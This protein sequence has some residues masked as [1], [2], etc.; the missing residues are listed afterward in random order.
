MKKHNTGKL[1]LLLYLLTGSLY[2]AAQ[3]NEQAPL[4]AGLPAS[5]F[6]LQSDTARMRF[7]SKAIDDSLDASQLDHVMQWARTGLIIAEK[8][9]VDTMKGIFLFDIGKAFTFRYNQYDSA[10]VY[11]KKVLPYFPDRLSR[12]NFWTTREIMERYSDLGNKDSSFTYLNMLTAVV[13]TMPDSSPRKS[14]I[15]QNIAGVYQGFGM[16]RTAMRYYQVA[17]TGTRLNKN[18]GGLG[19][20]L[21]NLAELYNQ[22]GNT[23]KAIQYS[24]EALI[25]LANFNMPYMQTAGNIAEYYT[26]QLNYDSALFYLN[27]SIAIAKKTNDF[28]TGIINQN[29][30]ALIYIAQKKFG[31]AKQLLDKSLR[32]LSGTENDW[33]RCKT[34]LDHATLDT[35]IADWAGAK[36]HLQEAISVALK[37]NFTSFTVP[38]FE[39]L[40]TVCTKTGDLRSA[41]DYHVKYVNM[42]DSL[43]DEKTKADLADLEVSY[44]TQ[45][46]EN[47][48]ELLKKDNDIKKLELSN[49]K[50]SMILY[51]SLLVFVILL[52]SILYY[53]RTQRNKIE[54][55]KLKAELETQVLRLQMNPH[56]IFNSLN[57]IEN[58]IM[59]NE[60]RL[61]SDY[62]NKFARL[63]RMILDSSRNELVP[64]AKDMEALQ[65]YVDL[66][67]LRFNNKFSYH[68]IV[69]PALLNGDYRVPSLLVQPY[70]ENA[71]VHGL[72]HSEKDNLT[73]TVS[74]TMENN[75]IKYSIT[76]N[77][78]GRKQA[79]EY[80]SQNKPYHKSVGLSITENRIINFNNGA[81]ITSPVKITDLYDK[82]NQ[83]AG[84]TIEITL[85]AI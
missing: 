38:A 22:T 19:I 84:T 5:Y 29:R 49:N 56:F 40:S 50:R 81:S 51:L 69:D 46:K 44:K 16:N 34:L 65:L 78:I 36:M 82:D 2:A 60:K 20:T 11:Y 54:T 64:V 76:D 33:S 32:D 13:D 67:Q 41:L 57:S 68:S 7:L 85:Q 24:K 9:H 18:F 53:Q 63:I 83:P 10:I 17:V 77:G 74:A 23:G 58:F 15:Y 62:L 30:L 72:A 80:N 61:A 37:N 47:E 52:L 1:L 21:A 73:L 59:Q 12:Y 39:V 28:E 14:R 6:K 71:V 55:Q 4:P 48:I 35:A 8:N 70:V 79:A 3:K 43:A 27:Q 42:K 45:Q 66:E 31:E 25:Y 75:N 26:S